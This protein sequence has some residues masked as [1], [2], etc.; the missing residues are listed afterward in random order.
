MAADNGRLSVFISTPLEVEQVD[1]I[2]AVAPDHLD[3]VYEPDLLP[4]KRYEADHGGSPSFRRTAEQQ[5]RWRANLAQA[6][7]LW[8]FPPTDPDGTG[9]LE[10]A[11][12]VRWI[13]TTSSGVGQRIRGLGL[14]DSELLITTARGVHAG[15]LSEFVFFVLLSYVRRLRHLEDEQRRHHWERFCGDE[16]EG[17]T[18]GIVGMGEVGRRVAS[19]GRCFGMRVIAVSRRDSDHTADDLGIDALFPADS[20]HEMLGEADALVLSV[21]HTAETEGLIDEAA[22]GALKP[23][24]VFV[25]IARGQVVDEAALTRG[26]RE[27][28]IAFAGLDVFAVEP[29]PPDSPLWDLPNVIISPHSSAN[30]DRENRKITDIFCHNLACYV[31]GRYEDMRNVFDK[32]KMY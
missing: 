10:H 15:P 7:I 14:L 11:T 19:V 9:G 16:L 18:L 5:E 22:F 24:A 20:L 32:A 1:R 17:K 30:A 26:L 8:D 27:G 28:A 13:Q 23:G 4:P 31:E 25:N 6:D 12:N 3:V 29:L 2:R 21:P